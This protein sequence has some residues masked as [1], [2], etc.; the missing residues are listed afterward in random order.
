MIMLM[1][2]L[3][4]MMPKT[5]SSL[6]EI[7]V[8]STWNEFSRSQLLYISQLFSKSFEQYHFKVIALNFLAHIKI[9]GEYNV[10]ETDRYFFEIKFHKTKHFVSASLYNELLK[11]I[12]YLTEVS[13]LSNQLI[14]HF[15][16][17]KQYFG[18]DN[19]LYNISYNELIHA[20]LAYSNF[21]N[22][23]DIKHLAT[24]AAILYRPKKRKLNKKSPK[25][26][27]DIRQEFSAYTY[28]YRA[29]WFKWL[30]FKTKYAIYIFFSGSLNQMADE[31]PLCFKASTLISSTP[32]NVNPAKT[33]IDLVPVITKGDPTKNKALYKSPAWDV[34]DAYERMREEF[35]TS[36]PNK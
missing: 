2:L 15:W 19:S 24:L 8:P 23:Q 27:G 13:T 7:K 5:D 14:P 29:K 26:N 34:F 12:K 32:K 3:T 18:P 30:P 28:K 35:E 16:M 33:L 25:W 6:P 4:K 9:T 36:K 20:Q 11:S 31:H 21:T 22:S 1:K 10:D 17:G